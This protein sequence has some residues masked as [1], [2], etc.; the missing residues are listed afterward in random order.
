[1]ILR[2]IAA[3]S[4]IAAFLLLCAGFV[5]ATDAPA[6]LLAERYQGGIDVSQYWVSEKLD[7][8]R[9]YWDGRQLRFRSGNVILA[10]AWF[11]A[12]LPAHSLDGELWLGRGTFERLS[13]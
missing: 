8:V 5:R 7:G 12:A 4:A 2:R 1:M 13:G 11:I 6:L 3:F 10:P 9:A